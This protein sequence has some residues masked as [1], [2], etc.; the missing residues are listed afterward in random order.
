MNIYQWL[1]SHLSSGEMY[2]L[3]VKEKLNKSYPQENLQETI[4]NVNELYL[5]NY[6]WTHQDG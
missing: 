1:F 5:L 4:G 2:Y 6:L 3:A